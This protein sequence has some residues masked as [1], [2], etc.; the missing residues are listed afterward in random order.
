[1]PRFLLDLRVLIQRVVGTQRGKAI[2]MFA[3]VIG[4]INFFFQFFYLDRN[5][6]LI[7]KEVLILM[8]HTYQ[9]GRIEILCFVLSFALGMIKNSDNNLGKK[10]KI[11]NSVIN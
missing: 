10:L 4:I 8:L 11:Y 1:M 7:Y 9:F 3:K 5:A 6:Q 2:F